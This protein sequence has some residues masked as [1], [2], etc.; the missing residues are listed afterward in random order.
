MKQ[1]LLKPNYCW[2]GRL[3]EVGWDLSTGL[4]S[5]EQANDQGKNQSRRVEAQN[6]AASVCAKVWGDLLRRDR[7]KLD[8]QGWWTLWQIVD[9]FVLGNEPAWESQACDPSRPWRR[10]SYSCANLF[11]RMMPSSRRLAVKWLQLKGSCKQQDLW[12]SLTLTYVYK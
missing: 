3:R 1:P 10:D 8:D 6:S 4:S 12:S 5:K 7:E 2:R 11:Q 9:E